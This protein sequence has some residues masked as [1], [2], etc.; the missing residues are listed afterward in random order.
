ME[1][2]ASGAPTDTVRVHG[3]NDTPELKRHDDDPILRS[4][5]SFTP[6]AAMCIDDLEVYDVDEDRE[7]LVVPVCAPSEMGLS[8]RWERV[9]ID[10][11]EYVIP[12]FQIVLVPDMTWVAGRY[13][14]CPGYRHK[15]FNSI[16]EVREQYE[17]WTG[18]VVAN[19]LAVDYVVDRAI[20]QLIEQIPLLTDPTGMSQYS[21]RHSLSIDFYEW[22]PVNKSDKRPPA[23]W[24]TAWAAAHLTQPDFDMWT[25]TAQAPLYNDKKLSRPMYVAMSK[26][27]DKK[28]RPYI[29]DRHVENLAK[30]LAITLHDQG[31][32]N[33]DKDEE[34]GVEALEQN[35][36]ADCEKDP[37]RKRKASKA[38]GPQPDMKGVSVGQFI[39]RGQYES[40]DNLDKA[41]ELIHKRDAQISEIT[42]REANLAKTC[43]D[44]LDFDFKNER[45]RMVE[46]FKDK[47]RNLQQLLVNELTAVKNEISL[48]LSEA[49]KKVDKL[50]VLNEKNTAIMEQQELE[51]KDMQKKLDGANT[52]TD[53]HI[54]KLRACRE[55]R[56]KEAAAFEEMLLGVQ[57]SKDATVKQE[58][59]EGQE[60]TAGAMGGRL[61]RSAS[62]LGKSDSKSNGKHDNKQQ[63]GGGTDLEECGPFA[64]TWEP[65]EKHH[66]IMKQSSEIYYGRQEL[67]VKGVLDKY[68]KARNDVI[69]AM[70][71]M[72]VNGKTLEEVRS[73]YEDDLNFL[74]A[75]AVKFTSVW[76]CYPMKYSVFDK[77]T[78]QMCSNCGEEQGDWKGNHKRGGACNSDRCNLCVTLQL[79]LKDGKEF[80]NKHP[81]KSCPF[82]QHHIGR[83]EEML[84]RKFDFANRDLKRGPPLDQL[85]E[86]QG[87]FLASLNE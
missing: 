10:G 62:D 40:I 68:S 45:D 56:N 34:F 14:Q 57:D 87:S 29:K 39:Q 70:K 77:N 49:T 18:S 73:E 37:K 83:F 79:G 31:S 30:R 41:L 33:M 74:N 24:K 81:T 27:Y 32:M 44:E 36:E 8:E 43:K 47:E 2:E 7:L 25:R 12:R 61:T 65:C 48:S 67:S 28:K 11:D 19:A 80:C 69:N 21:A 63:W 38:Q 84:M 85:E 52:R 71:R 78:V 50:E 42:Q 23:F 4:G 5:R 75:L 6:H 86:L 26:A 35:E 64:K 54:L 59:P 13:S 53:E 58:T 1:S 15:I 16:T 72:S 82:A 76:F 9:M 22:E 17:A 60:A 55:S 46:E 20:K 66:E 3:I 51:I